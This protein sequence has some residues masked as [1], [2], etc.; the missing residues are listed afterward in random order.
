MSSV[1]MCQHCVWMVHPQMLTSYCLTHHTCSRCN[2][3]AD[4][5]LVRAQ[6]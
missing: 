4:C 6:G 3:S 2:R 5:A 1:A